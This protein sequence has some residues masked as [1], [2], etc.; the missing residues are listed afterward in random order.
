MA[1]DADRLSVDSIIQRLLEDNYCRR[2]F[3]ADLNNKV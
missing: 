2:T 1:T 3:E